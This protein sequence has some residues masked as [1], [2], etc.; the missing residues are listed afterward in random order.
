MAGSPK[1][2]LHHE[3]HPE[4]TEAHEGEREVYL[5]NGRRLVVGEAN[6]NQLVEIRSDSGAVE[7]RI[8]LTEAGPVL[9]MEAVKLSLKAEQSIELESR[10]VA[11]KAGEVTIESEDTVEVDAGGEVRVA[12]KMIYLN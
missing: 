5:Q 10:K 8:E 4:T 12:G 6:G 7:V 3:E 11:I 1:E 2:K 9:R